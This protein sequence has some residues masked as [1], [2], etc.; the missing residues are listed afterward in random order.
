MEEYVE[1]TPES[2]RPLSDDPFSR[3]HRI[4]TIHTCDGEAFQVK[5][6]VIR[7][8]DT[9]ATMLDED[10]DE[11]EIALPCVSSKCMS[12]VIEFCNHCVCE[13]PMKAIPRPLPS[14][15]LFDLVQDWYARFALRHY[16]CENEDWEEWYRITSMLN[17]LGVR[18]LFL[19]HCAVLARRCANKTPQQLAEL[20]RVDLTD[21]DV[22]NITKNQRWVNRALLDSGEREREIF[23]T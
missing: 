15:N 4:V 17:Y 14:L 20:F 16:G 22:Q 6:G 11:S 9:I 18:P 7:L 23:L 8:S 13:E 5:E 21:A 1:Y 10:G 3:D 12:L 19:L 2:V